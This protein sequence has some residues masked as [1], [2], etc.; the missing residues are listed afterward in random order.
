MQKGNSTIFNVTNN[1]NF[2]LDA[3]P[4]SEITIANFGD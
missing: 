3:Y 4:F 1:M 2:V